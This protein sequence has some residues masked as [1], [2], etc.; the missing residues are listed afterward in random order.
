[1]A[2]HRGSISTRSWSWRS[3]D[4]HELI[5]VGRSH[6][7]ALRGRSYDINTEMEPEDLEPLL[8]AVS[9]RVGENPELCEKARRLGASVA[10][11][12]D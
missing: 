1:M 5:P 7:E 12:P 10:H 6:P 3:G 2:H 11:L 8:E 4:S 9:D